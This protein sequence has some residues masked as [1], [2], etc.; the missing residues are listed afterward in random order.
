MGD[1]NRTQLGIVAESAF[2]T[3]PA[4]P[5]FETLRVTS[6]GLKFTPKTVTSDEIRADG[7]VTDLILVGEEAGGPVGQELSYGACD[8]L[9]QGAM[10]SAWVAKPKI[11]NVTADSNITDAGTTANTY[12]VTSGG[13]AFKANML[14]R[15]TGFTNSANNQIFPVASSTGTTVVGTTLGLTAETAPPA[16]AQLQVIG[17]Q[18][19]SGDLTLTAATKT[20]ASTSLDFT[21]LGLVA[22]EWVK[23]GGSA[24]GNKFATAANNDWYR[25]ASIAAHAIVFDVVPAGLTDDTGTGKT[26]RVFTGDYIR[27]GTTEY[28]YTI[29]RQY[30]DLASPA[31]EYFRGQEIDE[32]VFT[33]DAEKIVTVETTF[34]G[35]DAQIGTTRQSGATD[36]AAPTNAVINTSANVGQITLGG[37]A[38]AG[39]SYVKTASLSIK[40]NLRQ[41][42]A[43][44]ILGAASI[45][46]GEVDV[47]G[48]W[49]VYFGDTSIY[50]AI[51]ANTASAMAIRVARSDA[52]GQTILFDV[53]RTKYS[54]GSPSVSG[55]NQD[56]M[57]PAKYQGLM[58]PTLGYTAQVSRYPYVE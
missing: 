29:E 54:D 45:G 31:Y 35:K 9:L 10:R 43:V 28:S 23:I 57:L 49:N 48:D 36:I 2:G 44:G 52:N 32:M 53:P 20:L 22:G 30:Q 4:N 41:R 3:I 47:T 58:H 5:A 51:L 21:T 16:G 17:F 46:S 37:V 8:T 12:A 25:I 40:R 55:K 50:S 18:G 11:L 14:C 27:N 1:T 42:T 24:A 26:I 15:A 34:L 56:V 19:A 39:P 7:Q 33:F 38:V 13:A 6:S